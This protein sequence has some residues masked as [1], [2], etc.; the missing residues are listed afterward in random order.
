VVLKLLTGRS[1]VQKVNASS[2]HT[3]RLLMSGLRFEQINNDPTRLMVTGAN[4]DKG[5]LEIPSSYLYKGKDGLI[6][7][8][9]PSA[10]ERNSFTKVV[11]PPTLT[12]INT[13]AFADNSLL[14]T[15]EF[16]TEKTCTFGHDAFEGCIKLPPRFSGVPARGRARM[17]R[18]GWYLVLALGIVV[19]MWF[20]RK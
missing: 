10:F 2:E 9:G 12:A 1:G 18:W 6:R 19:A 15:L 16:P 11:L 17:P 20:R 7:E 5:V 3:G 4:F 14:A 13:R 8:I